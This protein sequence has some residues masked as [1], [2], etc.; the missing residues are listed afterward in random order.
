MSTVYHP[1]T[2]GQTE[3]TNSTLEQYLRICVNYLQNNWADLSPL[4]KFAY[5]NSTSTTLKESLFFTNYGFNPTWLSSTLP[6]STSS[7]VSNH[8]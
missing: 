3:K 2:D 1:Q 4:A 8:L 5:N 7:T 6:T